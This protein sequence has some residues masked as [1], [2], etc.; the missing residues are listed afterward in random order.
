M[1][2]E[3]KMIIASNLTNAAFL[4]E[5]LLKGGQPAMQTW[6]IRGHNEI[7][8]RHQSM[9]EKCITSPNF[10]CSWISTHK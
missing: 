1:T 2:K 6:Q 5:Q 10:Q 4:R 8:H 3:A 9:R 7:K